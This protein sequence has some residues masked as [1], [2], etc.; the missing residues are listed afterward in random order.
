MLFFVK[1]TDEWLRGD[2]LA[3]IMLGIW[4]KK[5][6]KE[7][8]KGALGWSD[9]EKWC[10]SEKEEKEKL[11]MQRYI[12]EKERKEKRQEEKENIYR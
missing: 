4:E 5:T 6:K 9:L 10:Q 3:G 7:L 2:W 8:K 11:H 1:Q 12:G